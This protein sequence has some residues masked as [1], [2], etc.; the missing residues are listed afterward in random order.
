MKPLY[1]AELVAERVTGQVVVEGTVGG[2]G[3]VHDLKVVNAPHPDLSRSV[4]D[5]VSAWQFDPTLL[6][7]D[8]VDVKITVTAQ[9]ALN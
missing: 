3:L 5:A 8:P 2:N 6:N 7:C 9:F 1:P 4:L